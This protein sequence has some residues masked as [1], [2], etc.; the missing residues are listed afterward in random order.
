MRGEIIL[1]TLPREIV[2]DRLLLRRW[3]AEDRIPFAEMNADPRV[4]EFFPAP[5]S[6]AESDA[7]AERI[8]KNID[9]AYSQKNNHGMSE[10]IGLLTIGLLFPEL[11]QSVVIRKRCR[12]RPVQYLN[13]IIEQ[14]H[15]SIKED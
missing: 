10:A 12:H 5:L 6:R 2:T 13:N 3:R 1:S 11:Q 4:M 8:E 14:D 15:R 7:V 9:Y